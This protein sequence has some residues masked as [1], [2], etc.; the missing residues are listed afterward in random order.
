MLEV[1]S[2]ALYVNLVRLKCVVT[3]II[4]MCVSASV[5]VYEG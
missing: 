3:N 5:K 4:Q 1:Y 2:V